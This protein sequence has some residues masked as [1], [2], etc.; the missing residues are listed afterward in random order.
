MN[1]NLGPHLILSPMVSHLPRNKQIKGTYW[2]TIDGLRIKRCGRMHIYVVWTSSWTGSQRIISCRFKLVTQQ[3]AFLSC[4]RHCPQTY[5]LGPYT[6]EKERKGTYY[7]PRFVCG[8]LGAYAPHM[9]M[10]ARNW[11]L[12]WRNFHSMAPL[13]VGGT[14][15]TFLYSL[16]WLCWPILS[17]ISLLL[18]SNHS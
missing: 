4:K 11:K 7:G 5:N 8:R 16:E 13:H 18:A 6:K 10:S 17:L 1:R 15:F 12:S 9:L 14:Y 2:L 3:C